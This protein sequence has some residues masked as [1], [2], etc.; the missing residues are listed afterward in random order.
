MDSRRPISLPCPLPARFPPLPSFS[1][2][3]QD[4]RFQPVHRAELPQL[5]VSVSLL[6]D[7]EE[8]EPWT[9]SDW[10]I[11]THG[12]LIS[13]TCKATRQSYSATYL[14]GV[15]Q[16]Q[17]WS[18]HQGIRSLVRKAGFAKALGKSGAQLTQG[19]RR[20]FSSF[21]VT[22]YRSSKAKLTHAGY[23]RWKEQ[24]VRLWMRQAAAVAG[25]GSE[26]DGASAAMT[27]AGAAATAAA[28]AE[29]GVRVRA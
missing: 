1:H 9:W 10:E 21:S 29:D 16:E 27:A 17:R 23:R 18:K 7:Y 13:F 8:C 19:I 15:V 28:E 14:P 22:R 26:G 6:T 5:R 4:R 25:E 24:R 11:D 20:H 12:I 2:T 3:T